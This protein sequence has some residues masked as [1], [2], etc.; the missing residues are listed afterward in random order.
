MNNRIKI[1]GLW[2][3]TDKNGNEYFSGGLNAFNNILIFANTYKEKQTDPDFIMYIAE[4][5][6]KEVADEQF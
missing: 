2:K 3:N 4:K 6:K 1:G 5:E